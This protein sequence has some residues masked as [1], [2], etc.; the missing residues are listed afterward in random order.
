MKKVRVLVGVLVGFLLLTGCGKKVQEEYYGAL[1]SNTENKTV[2][3]SFKIDQLEL[4]MANDEDAAAGML[5]NSIL[6]SLKD[7]QLTG[8]VANDTKNDRLQMDLEVKVLGSTFPVE[9]LTDNKKQVAYMS[10]DIYQQIMTLAG[11]LMGSGDLGAA[12]DTEALKGK[13]LELNAEDMKDLLA[14]SGNQGTTESGTA[15]ITALQTNSGLMKKWLL[16][17]EAD[18]FKKD[19]DKISHTFT[20]EELSDFVAYAEKNGDKEAKTA[21]S[22]L[23]ETL[24][25]LTV[26]DLATTVDTK[27]GAQDMKMTMTG[28]ADGNTINAAFSVTM[29]PTDKKAE[30]KM[31]AADQIVT[32]E[33]LSDLLGAGDLS[34][35]DLTEEDYD[36]YDEGDYEEEPLTDEEFQQMYDELAAT[37]EDY[38]PEE[39]Q[40][41]LDIFED[42]VT[43]EQFAKLQ[44]L[45]SEG[46]SL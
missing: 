10:T 17:L 42:Y 3:I 19:G 13:Y 18:T 20:K 24:Q 25:D 30:V 16:T 23:K 40:D 8:T 27:N 6:N 5:A 41:Y 15:A 35:S 12:V 33:Q 38:T 31:P 46:S 22:Q 9:I 14:S 11:S 4:A 32:E 44:E 7:A 28:A 36:F 37:K 39:L 1:N 45:L 21:A 34:S 29:K 2:D 26:F 43:P